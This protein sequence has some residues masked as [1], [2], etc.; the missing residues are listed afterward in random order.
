MAVYSS[1]QIAYSPECLRCLIMTHLEL[2]HVDWKPHGRLI[3]GDCHIAQRYTVAML[4][5]LS[6]EG[7]SEHAVEAMARLLAGENFCVNQRTA[8]EW[9]E[10]LDLN[11]F[12]E[13]A[14]YQLN[15][16]NC[17]YSGK[18]CDIYCSQHSLS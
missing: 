12:Q 15:L 7:Q 4:S 18:T 16:L 2:R 11:G 5:T 8:A 3:S 14:L 17:V 10:M 13:E 9:A 6:D 1:S